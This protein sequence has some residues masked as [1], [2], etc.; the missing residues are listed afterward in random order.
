MA[1]QVYCSKCYTSNSLDSKECSNCNNP[2][3]RDKKYRVSVSVKGKRVNRIVE[4]LTIAKELESTTKADMVREEFDISHHKV[5]EKPVTLNEV[6][7]K[8][9]PWAQENKKTWK[10][11]HYNY[12]THL[13]PRWGI[14]ALDA[15]T[16]MDV[17][18]LK[19]ELKRSVNKFGRPFTP[20]TIKHQLVLLNRLY[21]LEKRWRL[22]AGAN[23]MDHVEVPKLDNQVTE[24]MTDEELSRLLDVLDNWPHD[25]SAS[26]I[27]FALY[28]GF[29][30]GELFKLRWSNI[31]FDH[32]MITIERKGN[33]T[34]TLPVCQQ[35][36]EVLDGID[37]TSEFVFPGRGGAQRTDFKGPWQRIRK[38]AGLPKG[39]RF[40]GIRHHFASSLVSN[41]IDLFT[42][43]G[44]LS[45]KD[46]RTT[47]RYSHLMPGALQR[48]AEKAGEL[49][50]PKKVKTPL[51]MVKR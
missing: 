12:E 39:F 43:Q 30:R 46:S 33:K 15:I 38:L 21:N 13:K 5:K 20:A 2:F 40:H 1:I 37:R 49:L 4:N 16:S 36:F 3:G 6:W 48:A 34:V 10:C 29:R 11:D 44:L 25:D 8:Y 22:Y 7:V 32:H 28:T 19:L 18:R 27:K 14:K 41:G 17:E 26:F 45:H 23:P 9:L 50:Q 31:D 42:V 24:F 51:Q 35:A 47:A